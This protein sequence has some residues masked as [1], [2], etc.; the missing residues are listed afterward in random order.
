MIW[1]LARVLDTE[2]GALQVEFSAPE[3]CRRCSRGEGCGAGVFS[4]LFSRRATAVQLSADLSVR[5]G[6]WVRV[7]IEPVQLAL[8]AGRLYGLGLLGLLLGI[9]AGHFLAA[10]AAWQDLAAL[11][12]GGLGLAVSVGLA[13]RRARR[14]W[15]PVVER[16]S[17][18]GN[19]AKSS[20]DS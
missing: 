15:N 13:R 11:S 19:D 2:P 18:S 7:G 9:L 20:V 8:A 3:H 6:D 12:G 4:R 10:G 1:Q 17:C 5:P 14:P 16:L